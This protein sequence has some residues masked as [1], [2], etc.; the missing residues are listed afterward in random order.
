MDAIGSDRERPAVG[1]PRRRVSRVRWARRVATAA[2]RALAHRRRALVPAFGRALPGSRLRRRRSGHRGKRMRGRAPRSV[3][4]TATRGLRDPA[5]A[6][7]LARLGLLERGRATLPL[8][9]GPSGDRGRVGACARAERDRAG[10][11]GGRVARRLVHVLR[12][13]LRAHRAARRFRDRQLPPRDQ[14]VPWGLVALR[15]PFRGDRERTPTSFSLRAWPA[16]CRARGPLPK[17][18]LGRRLRNPVSRQRSPVRASCR[19]EVPP[20]S[21]RLPHRR[22]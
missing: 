2:P 4:R 5:R 13:G 15:W 8:P 11:P 12:P 20:F 22:R 9:R 21:P 19:R 14:D 1:S 17:D 6:R 16:P 10:R 3:P 18:R 7:G